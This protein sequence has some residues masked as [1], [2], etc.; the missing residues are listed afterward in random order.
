MSSPYL[1]LHQGFNAHR[2]YQP[3]GDGVS[4]NRY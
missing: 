4:A 1:T 2:N 3:I